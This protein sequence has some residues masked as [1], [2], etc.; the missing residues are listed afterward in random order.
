MDPEESNLLEKLK[1]NS[2]L[3]NEE[4][5]DICA[6]YN[7]YLTSFREDQTEQDEIGLSFES[8]RDLDGN[9]IAT[10]ILDGYTT[11]SIWKVIYVED[12]NVK[13]IQTI[14]DKIEDV[15]ESYDNHI[16]Q[17]LYEDIE[18]ILAVELEKDYSNINTTQI[19]NAVRY[20]I[21]SQGEKHD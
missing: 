14:E 10:L 1:L 6:A 3:S 21:D 16:W 17:M 5:Q 12:C 20:F 7:L 11:Q 13:N 8:I 15:I 9:H 19:W 4:L 18:S 2:C